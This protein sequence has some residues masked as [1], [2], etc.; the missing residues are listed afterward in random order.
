MNTG[1]TAGDNPLNI[2]AL[3]WGLSAALVVLFVISWRSRSFCRIGE[4]RTHGSACSLSH[5]GHRFGFGSS[6]LLVFGW[7][8]AVIPAWSTTISSAVEEV[9]NA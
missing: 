8:S 2:V 7:V 9:R 6:A 4:P 3:G 5:Q 1:A